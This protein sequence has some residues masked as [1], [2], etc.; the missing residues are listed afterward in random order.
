MPRSGSK[1]WP[2]SPNKERV[3]PARLQYNCLDWSRDT[4]ARF[5]VHVSKVLAGQAI[6]HSPQQG[7]HAVYLEESHVWTMPRHERGCSVSTITRQGLGALN[8]VP[9]RVWVPVDA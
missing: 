3:A 5:P 4:V 9:G 2:P 1:D 7:E 8:A 6:S